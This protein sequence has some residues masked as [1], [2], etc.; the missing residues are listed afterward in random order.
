MLL[1]P[2]TLKYD[3][4]N[5]S[6]SLYSVIVYRSI[7]VCYLISII[8]L[9]FFQLR[10]MYIVARIYSFKKSVVWASMKLKFAKISTSSMF[11]STF[12]QKSMKKSLIKSMFQNWHDFVLSRSIKF[13]QMLQLLKLNI[14]FSS[15]LQSLN[16]III[17]SIDKWYK[18]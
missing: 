9:F 4:S 11:R 8:T 3:E 7:N 18:T 6:L 16:K 2:L 13:R 17:V 15:M 12:C 10:R 14:L 1:Q 5:L